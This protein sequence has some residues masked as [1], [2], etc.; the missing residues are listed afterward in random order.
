MLYSNGGEGKD[1]KGRIKTVHGGTRGFL[2]D[3]VGVLKELIQ[4]AVETAT[5]QK[6]TNSS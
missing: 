4:L 6:D 5:F 3:F 2:T 1:N